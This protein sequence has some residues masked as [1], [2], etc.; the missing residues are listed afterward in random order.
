MKLFSSVIRIKYA[1]HCWDAIYY[2]LPCLQHSFV[3]SENTVEKCG[4]VYY[5]KAGNITA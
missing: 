5:E 3:H 4:A 2:V 1:R